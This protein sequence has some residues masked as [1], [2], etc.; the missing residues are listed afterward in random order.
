MPSARAMVSEFTPLRL[1]IVII[2]ISG[3]VWL[4][5]SVTRWVVDQVLA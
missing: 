1:L 4:T 3:L 2:L 5:R